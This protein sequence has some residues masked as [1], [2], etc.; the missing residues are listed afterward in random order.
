MPA[1]QI[2]E[3]C[4]EHKYK[5]NEHTGDGCQEVGPGQGFVETRQGSSANDTKIRTTR[6]ETT[7]KE[8]TDP[9]CCEASLICS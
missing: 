3:D 9:P 6:I 4:P 5:P 7:C 8:V 1:R 2:I